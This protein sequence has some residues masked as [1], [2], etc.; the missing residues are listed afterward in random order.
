MLDITSI[1]QTSIRVMVVAPDATL[2]EAIRLHLADRYPIEIVHSAQMG[3]QCLAAIN[4]VDP[5]VV[6]VAEGLEDINSLQL[7]RQIATAFPAVAPLVLSQADDPQSYHDIISAG[8][9]GVVKI[10][11]V[12]EGWTLSG[13]ELETR[14]HQADDLVRSVRERLTKVVRRPTSTLGRKTIVVYSPKGGVGKSAFAVGLALLLA[15]RDS[16][17]KIALV[18]L[19]LQFGIDSVYL[20]LQPYHSIVDMIS[21]LDTLSAA[22]LDSLAR[23]ELESGVEL[24]YVAAPPNVRQADEILGRNVAGVLGALRRYCDVTIVD[25][26]ATI[27]D[28]TLAALQAATRILL[29]CTQDMLAIRETR[30]VLELLHDPEFGIAPEIIALVLNKVNQH[31]EIKPESIET[32]FELECFGG[33]PEDNIFFESVVNVGGLANALTDSRPVIKAWKEVLPK[34]DVEKPLLGPPE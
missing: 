14:I 8:A 24:Y 11:K 20:N 30:V 10:A 6:L 27:S 33:I 2:V 7:A 23:R 25:T 16:K 13:E 15:K 5:H 19:N 3:R 18:D 32:L 21:N 28:V 22:T 4:D 31:S 1:R 17:K 9:R 34:L 12:P 26:T 29:V